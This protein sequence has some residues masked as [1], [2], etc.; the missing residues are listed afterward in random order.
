MVRKLSL[1]A[2]QSIE[3]LRMRKQV[4]VQDCETKAKDRSRE[5]I[6]TKRR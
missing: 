2:A 5:G 3:G 1:G 6:G 4:V